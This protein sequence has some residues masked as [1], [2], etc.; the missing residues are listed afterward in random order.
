HEGICRYGIRGKS[1]PSHWSCSGSGIG[2]WDGEYGQLPGGEWIIGHVGRVRRRNRIR[3]SFD[4][5]SG[6]PEYRAAGGNTIFDEQSG[7]H[8]LCHTELELD[9]IAGGQ[10]GDGGQ[11]EDSFRA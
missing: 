9:T 8:S 5:S 4:E 1:G 11:G 6:E 2:N 10:S 7:E 3:K